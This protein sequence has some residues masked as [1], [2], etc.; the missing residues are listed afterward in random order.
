[1]IHFNSFSNSFCSSAV[2]DSS[3]GEALTVISGAAGKGAFN[4]T[5]PASIGPNP[6]PMGGGRGGGNVAGGS[7]G[8]AGVE[9]AGGGGSSAGGGGAGRPRA[10]GGGGICVL[11]V[12]EAGGPAGVSGAG[13]RESAGA[14]SD[15]SF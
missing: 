2:N 10:A 13:A 4:G 7:E 9:G 11:L 3:T 6:S 14:E 12:C 5:S 8:V 15:E 1:M